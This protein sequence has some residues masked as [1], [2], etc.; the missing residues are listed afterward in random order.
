MNAKAAHAQDSSAN[1]RVATTHP[2]SI[3]RLH[4][5]TTRY[6]THLMFSIVCTNITVCR[7]YQKQ[8]SSLPYSQQSPAHRQTRPPPHGNH[9]LICS[10]YIASVLMD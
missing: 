1:N 7:A 4:S 3:R 10:L 6:S 5:L 9:L 2:E 8:S